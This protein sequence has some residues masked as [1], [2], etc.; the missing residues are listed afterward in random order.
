[1]QQAS[2]MTRR[3]KKVDSGTY[4]NDQVVPPSIAAVAARNLG[5]YFLCR[6]SSDRRAKNVA[7][8]G[9]EGSC[10]V[11]APALE[12]GTE[13]IALTPDVCFCPSSLQDRNRHYLGLDPATLTRD[14]LNSFA[15]KNRWRNSNEF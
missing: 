1:V 10:S 5:I 11:T 15:S 7:E 9:R 12:R 2:L 6:R 14:K 4:Y 8:F 13:E 3:K